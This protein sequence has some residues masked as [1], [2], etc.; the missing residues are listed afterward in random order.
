VEAASFSAA[1]RRMKLS[2][3]AVSKRVSDLEAHLG[4]E[5]LRRTSRKVVATDE[6]VQFYQRVRP[7][8]EQ[9]DQATAELGDRSQV[10]GR[11][12]VCAPACLGALYVAPMLFAFMR[13]HPLLQLRLELEDRDTGILSEGYDLAICIGPLPD[14]SLVA[15]RLALSPRVVCCSPEYARRSGLPTALE[16]L[17]RHDCIG[18][19]TGNPGQPWLF[20][21]DPPASKP[22]AVVV[23]TRVE[24][25][26]SQIARAAALA[27]LGLAMLPKYLVTDALRNGDLVDAL[28]GVRPVADE[29][30]AVFPRSHFM[31]RKVRAVV[32]H[33]VDRFAEAPHWES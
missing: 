32:D 9:F 28:P 10:R 31:P 1:A 6:G 29:I 3:S 33:L 17:S 14:S 23:R 20:V 25:N 2:K 27:G 12:N 24:V 26:N 13:Q 11:L 30:H 5:L 4:T 18:Q 22:R 8:L 15:R 21:A 16:D 7:I 19:A